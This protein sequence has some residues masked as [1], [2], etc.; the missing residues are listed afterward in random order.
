[1]TTDTYFDDVASRWDEMRSGFY[2]EGV[3]EAALAAAKAAPGMTAADIGGGTGFITQALVDR[4]LKVIAVDQSQAMLDEMR[5]K[6]GHSAGIDYRL[7]EA[8]SLPLRD[9]AIDCAFANMYLHH[10]QVPA[11]AIKEMARTLKS[12]GT[13]V[14]TDLDAHGLEVL[15]EEHHDRW[16]G[17]ERRDVETWLQD[18]GL[19]GVSVDDVGE[20]CCA[21]SSCGAETAS[22][23]IFVALGVK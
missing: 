4:G 19:Q 16:L 10:V 9:G 15:R 14:I 1:M 12:G 3:R 17:F 20:D 5:K 23:S 6:F 8:S 2:T 7:G 13:L 22:V 11:E 18:A 21:D